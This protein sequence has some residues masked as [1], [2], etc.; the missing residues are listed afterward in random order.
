MNTPRVISYLLCRSQQI[1]RPRE[2][3]THDVLLRTPQIL[4]VVLAVGLFEVVVQQVPRSFTAVLNLE[5]TSENSA[6]VSMGDLDGD[7]DLDLVLAKGRHTPLL[8]RVLLNDGKGG[9]V[10]S[11]LGAAPDRTYAAV[12]ADVDGDHDLD[13]LTSNDNPDRKLVYL[14][15]GTGKF[16]V[17]G[18]WGVPEWSTR[19]ADVADLNGDSRIDVIAANRPGPSFVCL[20]EGGGRFSSECIKIPAPSATSIVPG[21]FDK[22][23]FVDLAVPSRDGGQSHIYFNNGKAGFARTAP[24]G[25]PDAAARVAAAADFNGDGSLDLAVGDERSAEMVVY[26]NNG[27]GRLTA[28]FRADDKGI[29]YAIAAEDLNND[30]HPDIVLGYILGPQSVFFNDGSGQR[31]THATFGDRDGYG[32]AYGFA[33]GDINGDKFP[34]IALARSGAPNVLYLSGAGVPV[35]AA[36]RPIGPGL[37]SSF[38]GATIEAAFGFGWRSQSDVFLGGRS[39][40]TIMLVAEGARGSAGSLLI[41]GEVAP[42]AKTPW[43]G[44]TFWPG[45]EVLWPANLSG[46]THL[47]FWAKGDDR[48]YFVEILARGRPGSTK[49]TFVAGREWREHTFALSGDGGLDIRKILGLNIAAGPESG[50]FALQI[51]EVR[52]R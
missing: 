41:E 25:P 31:F 42:T 32:S 26:L 38:D 50:R 3:S 51:D 12:L 4:S 30:R 48:T 13:V 37:V 11:D 33:I 16:T 20:N 10:A 18:E 1:S 2:E 24:F 21:D 36:A 40:A 19:N 17:S 6:N 22:D 5:T 15:N 28:G 49:A 14:N 45:Q 29:P 52:L 44:A 46:V 9:F 47:S 39:R 23:G 27:A 43:A 8:D 7:G 35:P 34:D